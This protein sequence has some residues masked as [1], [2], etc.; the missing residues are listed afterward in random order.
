MKLY[1]LHRATPLGM[2]LKSNVTVKSMLQPLGARSYYW[3]DFDKQ[4]KAPPPPSKS[5]P[6]HGGHYDAR[7]EGDP[8]L[9]K[10]FGGSLRQSI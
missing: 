9:K 6:V 3:K 1:E 5:G 10:F 7:T 2:A 4:T 8:R